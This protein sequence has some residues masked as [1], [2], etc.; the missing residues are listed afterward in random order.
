MIKDNKQ[1]LTVL[2]FLTFSQPYFEEL[3][4]VA[5]VASPVLPFFKNA[6]QTAMPVRNCMLED[7]VADVATRSL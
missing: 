5:A 4:K 1:E 6:L 3:T 7:I 2:L